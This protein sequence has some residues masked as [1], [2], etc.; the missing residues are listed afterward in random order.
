MSSFPS[1]DDG[2]LEPKCYNVDFHIKFFFLDNL[3]F[4]IF[5]ILSDSFPLIKLYILR[6]RERKRE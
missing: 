6:H 3:V 4:Q 5:S 1:L 2:P